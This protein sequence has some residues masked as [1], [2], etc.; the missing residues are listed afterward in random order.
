MDPARHDA[1]EGACIWRAM[2]TSISQSSV[3]V[4]I[5]MDAVTAERQQER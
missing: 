1:V 3:H 2:L 4:R 5:L